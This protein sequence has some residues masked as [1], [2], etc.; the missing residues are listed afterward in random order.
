M[1]DQL[2]PRNVTGHAAVQ[3]LGYTWNTVGNLS[4]R[5]DDNLGQVEDFAYDR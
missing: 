2:I 3:N 5:R 4:Q 1:A